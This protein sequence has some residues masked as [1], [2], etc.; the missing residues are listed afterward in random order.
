ML[1][2]QKALFLVLKR[3]TNEMS[4]NMFY[5]EPIVEWLFLINFVIHFTI[6]VYS[7]KGWQCPSYQADQILLL[8]ENLHTYVV[9]LLRT[10][11][12]WLRKRWQSERCL[13]YKTLKWSSQKL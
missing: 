2:E 9:R 12:P 5:K 1:L 10:I 11:L 3:D 7:K 13:Q 8:N 4:W 6:L